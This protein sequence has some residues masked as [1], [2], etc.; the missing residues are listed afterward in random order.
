MI[1]DIKKLDAALKFIAYTQRRTLADLLESKGFSKS[2]IFY[3]KKRKLGPSLDFLYKLFTTYDLNPSSFIFTA[4]DKTIAFNPITDLIHPEALVNASNLKLFFK[5]LVYSYGDY[6]LSLSFIHKFL[7]SKFPQLNM[8]LI[9]KGDK[10]HAAI[11]IFLSDDISLYIYFRLYHTKLY[12][13]VSDRNLNRNEDLNKLPYDHLSY[14]TILR[15]IKIIDLHST[16]IRK[17]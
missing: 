12:S 9:I 15:Y 1:L 16:Q 8:D 2:V 13:C 10:H 6:L 3:L 7:M 14:I 4:S 17:F 11:Q 5:Y